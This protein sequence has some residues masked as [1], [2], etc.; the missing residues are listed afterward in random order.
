M[1]TAPYYLL[2]TF[3][4]EYLR[5]ACWLLCGRPLKPIGSK[6]FGPLLSPSVYYFCPYV[7]R[8]ILWLLQRFL[9]GNHLR[10]H[11]NVSC[12]S[13][14]CLCLLTPTHYGGSVNAFLCNFGREKDSRSPESES[15]LKSRMMS[16][17]A[18]I[19]TKNRSGTCYSTRLSA[20]AYTT[21]LH[22]G[23]R[24]HARSLLVQTTKRQNKT[25]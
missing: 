4:A 22:N 20:T 2:H 17:I 14:T 15:S 9:R 23:G 16:K 18:F 24:Y 12:A 5:R 19:K 13:M 6:T 7:P 21:Q 1:P 25:S 10:P 11:I 8:S 3:S